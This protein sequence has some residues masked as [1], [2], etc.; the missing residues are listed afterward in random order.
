[1][2]TLLL[3][4]FLWICYVLNLN[5]CDT[6]QKKESRF[7]N[8]SFNAQHQSQ[9]QNLHTSSKLQGLLT[10]TAS[11][12]RV[13]VN[14]HGN[15]SP[16]AF[17]KLNFN[18]GRWDNQRLYKMY[19]FAL[20][21]EQYEQSSQ[22]SSVCLATQSSVERL[23]FLVQVAYQ[24]TGPISIAAFIAG[25]EEFQI[26]QYYITYLQ[27]CFPNIRNNLA[28]HIA[29][30]ADMVPTGNEKNIIKLGHNEN[31][32]CQY[33]EKTLRR[34]LKFRSSET[35]RW[36]L[37][38][39][40]P[41]NHMRNL[42]RKGCLNPYVFLTDIDIV[43]SRNITQQLNEF[44]QT[45]NCQKQCAFVIP[46][47]E[48]DIRVSFPS[49]K[50][51]LLELVKKGLARPFHEKVFIYN[52]FATNFSRWQTNDRPDN[53]VFVSH[54]VT[55]FE[56]L[57]E[58]FYVAADTVP[59]HDE[60]FLG[61]GFTRNSQVYEMYIAGYEFFVLSPIFTCHWGLQQKKTRPSW[62]E[63]QNNVNR[64]RFETF[65]LEILAKYKKRF[66]DIK[67]KST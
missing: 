11:T 44:I 43:P 51:E 52:Q 29:V 66:V 30:P 55:N 20:T 35:I 12:K 23:H 57:Y 47:Y 59:V 10:T 27:A 48:I 61:Y 19:D 49:S 34:L 67:K 39:V 62:R 22:N 40:Y 9:H 56:F 14:S 1:M 28:F 2:L 8:H 53:K 37:K 33:P 54:N 31:L 45:S 6:N 65:K 38:N 60:R 64:K 17:S 7:G 3:F 36:R 24:W 5:R 50:Q 41:Q 4:N 26:L 58:P 13:A 42:A 18:I 25:S 46:T 16:I 63:Q 15:V 32:C 21:G